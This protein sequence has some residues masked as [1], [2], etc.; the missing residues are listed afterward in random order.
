MVSPMRI[1]VVGS[2]EPFSEMERLVSTVNRRNHD[3][4]STA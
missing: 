1:A 2:F 3:V 4:V